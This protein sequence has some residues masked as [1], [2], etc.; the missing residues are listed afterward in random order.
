MDPHRVG[1]TRCCPVPFPKA[2]IVAVA[3]KRSLQCTA[4]TR[5]RSSHRMVHPVDVANADVLQNAEEEHSIRIGAEWFGEVHGT[6]AGSLSWLTIG[7]QSIMSMEGFQARGFAIT[8]NNSFREVLK[9]APRLVYATRGDLQGIHTV[10]DPDWTECPEVAA[11]LRANFAEPKCAFVIYD[12]HYK[13]WAVGLSGNSK[14]SKRR[15]RER[16]AYLALC[17]TLLFSQWSATPTKG[18]SSFLSFC[19]NHAIKIH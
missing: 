16:C 4:R 8:Y 6:P 12:R 2:T 1:M 18:F 17:L 11:A 7:Q 15:D 14:N 10:D 3:K 13:K 19:D 5:S 9:D